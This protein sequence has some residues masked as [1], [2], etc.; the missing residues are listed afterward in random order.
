MEAVIRGVLEAEEGAIAQ[1]RHLIDD[2]DRVDRAAMPYD[3]I[4]RWER[5]SGAFHPSS[6]TISRRRG[7]LGVCAST[8]SPTRRPSTAAPIADS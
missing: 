8:T 2:T 1:Y 7:P 3:P 5:E 6:S 4:E